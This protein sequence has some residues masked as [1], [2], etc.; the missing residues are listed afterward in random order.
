VTPRVPLWI[1]LRA[2]P[3]NKRLPYLH[4]IRESGAERVLLAA[5][6]P[7]L[8]KDGLRTIALGSRNALREDGV[9]IGRLI[10]LRDARGQERAA[11]AEGLV[12]ISARDWR[13]I[14]LE[15][16]VARRR[17]RPGTLF[18]LAHSPEDAQL[19][20]GAL[21]SGVHGI[22]LAP[23]SPAD[24]GATA[25]AL[26]DAR[27]GLP[28]TP[29]PASAPT[30]SGILLRSVRIERIEDGGLGDRVCIDATSQMEEGE[31]MLVGSTARSF[32][33]VHAETAT[34]P[35]VAP[36]PF[37]VN[38]GALH[39]YVL[40]PEGRTRY[41]SELAAGIQVLAVG[42]D[43]QAR[44]LVVGRA[45]MERRPLTILH[46]TDATGRPASAA[47]QTAETVRLL[48]T[49]GTTLALTALKVG[50][51]VL[52]HDETAARHVGLPVD[53]RLEER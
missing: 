18:A 37:R 41:L 25:R 43:G 12:I 15:N 26:V 17:D 31:G 33:L 21:E 3:V 52:A 9:E 46:W 27:R 32:I 22:V 53:E 47:L 24:V 45:K 35:F 20:A 49:D 4:A 40:A 2:V 16:L 11:T 6:D 42:R 51:E 19:F 30:A 38:A 10:E 36:R 39:M 50:D 34:N 8:E 5:G 7:H 14:P 13:V 28:T 44:P 23:R 48:R 29:P 1:D